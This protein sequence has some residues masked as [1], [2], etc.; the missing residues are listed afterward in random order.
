MRIEMVEVNKK[1][2]S[3]VEARLC[4]IHPGL[5]PGVVKREII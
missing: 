1:P 4:F 5:Q 2:Y 3:T